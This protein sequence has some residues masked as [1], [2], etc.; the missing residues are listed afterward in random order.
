MLYGRGLAVPR[1]GPVVA[2]I[3]VGLAFTALGLGAALAET[4][5]TGNGRDGADRVG[6]ILIQADPNTDPAPNAPAG[7]GDVNE[8]GARGEHDSDSDGPP[9]DPDADQLNALKHEI[10]ASTNEINVFIPLQSLLDRAETSALARYIIARE[11]L[12]RAVPDALLKLILVAFKEI[13]NRNVGQSRLL[14]HDYVHSLLTVRLVRKQ[15]EPQIDSIF[16]SYTKDELTLGFVAAF[17]TGNVK[18]CQLAMDLAASGPLAI[19]FTDAPAIEAP[20]SATA[21][22][23]LFDRQAQLS[24]VVPLIE[25]LEN[26]EIEAK[27]R[28]A[29]VRALSRITAQPF[30]TDASA[31]RVWW[32]AMEPLTPQQRVLVIDRALQERYDQLQR[33][34]RDARVAAKLAELN[35]DARNVDLVLRT[36]REA[37]G[38]DGA[39]TG[40]SDPRVIVRALELLNAID[41]PADRHAALLED[42]VNLFDDVSGEVRRTVARPLLKL[43]GGE[44]RLR[45]YFPLEDNPS[46]QVFFI[47]TLAKVAREEATLTMMIE[48]VRRRETHAAAVVRAALTGMAV[49]SRVEQ[50]TFATVPDVLV[51]LLTELKAQGT[52][53]LELTNA[54]VNAL[55]ELAPKID[56]Q[57][58]IAR[59]FALGGVLNVDQRLTILRSALSAPGQ[60][61]KSVRAWLPGFERGAGFITSVLRD[62]AALYWTV[63]TAVE[64]LGLQATPFVLDGDRIHELLLARYRT[65]PP[66]ANG[67]LARA[68]EQTWARMAMG[69]P[70]GLLPVLTWLMDNG[71]SREALNSVIPAVEPAFTARLEAEKALPVEQQLFT[72][73]APTLRPALTVLKARMAIRSAEHWSR[74]DAGVPVYAQ[75][76]AEDRISLAYRIADMQYA[77]RYQG[78]APTGLAPQLFAVMNPAR[79][80]LPVALW[81]ALGNQFESMLQRG[82]VD[83]DG[84]PQLA[85]PMLY[86]LSRVAQLQNNARI[87]EL[88]ANRTEPEVQRLKTIAAAAT[89]Q[90][91][92]WRTAVRKAFAALLATMPRDAATVPAEVSTYAGVDE[93]HRVVTFMLLDAIEDRGP[94]ASS[95][96][97]L[98]ALLADLCATKKVR[99]RETFTPMPATDAEAAVLLG[100]IRSDLT[101]IYG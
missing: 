71:A 99:D 47:E 96:K 62:E 5:A 72:A 13:A 30:G 59:V 84:V 74:D 87:A 51:A 40:S 79:A 1:T 57:A 28:D 6:P 88:L 73:Q 41:V 8:D 93:R 75:L 69:Q 78:N 38:G 42:L 10:L 24:F 21:K 7:P 25:V 60:T 20:P 76:V 91:D 81:Q 65:P 18:A 94:S 17:H 29:A 92:A 33:E 32:K 46:V 23:T 12:D 43:S 9:D 98:Y 52:T 15:Y 16:A 70:D 101:R 82:E 4:P 22:R 49:W 34:V 54:V 64:V 68:I 27:R 100:Q 26:P 86:V 83:A 95:S 63:R 80:E 61:A 37:V 39:A 50:P 58:T 35:D 66:G 97:A 77:F 90:R 36:I 44:E 19:T 85:G 67:A 45:D 56:T 3:A 2:V 31:W 55:N 48:I 89:K 14:R 53:D 11:L